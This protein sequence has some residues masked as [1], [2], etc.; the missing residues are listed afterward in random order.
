MERMRRKGNPPTLLVGMGEQQNANKKQK[1]K[2]QDSVTDKTLL[3]S[4]LIP[5]SPESCMSRELGVRWEERLAGVCP[6]RSA[7][8]TV[9]LRRQSWS[10]SAG[11][12]P[13]PGARV[14]TAQ[15]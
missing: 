12:G 2:Q 7:A 1:H 3:F 9:H 14:G 8:A 15:A 5:W 6:A 13:L 11:A 4:P 10:L